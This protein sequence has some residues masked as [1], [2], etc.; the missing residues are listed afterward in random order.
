MLRELNVEEAWDFC[1]SKVQN[2]VEFATLQWEE[3][4]G[5]EANSSNKQEG[6]KQRLVRTED[7]RKGLSSK[8]G[9]MGEVRSR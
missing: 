7:G 4:A 1:K 6:Y 9:S 5:G 3:K 2:H 8:A